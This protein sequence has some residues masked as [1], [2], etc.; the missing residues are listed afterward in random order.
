M[1]NFVKISRQIQN[2]PI[3]ELDF[4]RTVCVAAIW[5]SGPKSVVST[6]FSEEND[7]Q[8]FRSITQ[9]LRDVFA[10]IQTNWHG[11]NNSADQ[12]YIYFIASPTFISVC[13]KLYGK[14]KQQ[15]GIFSV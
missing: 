8:N 10:C 14:L 9:K 2:F 13:Y 6:A 3:Q 4:N 5:N 12:L 1:S 7:G 15:Q 11:Y